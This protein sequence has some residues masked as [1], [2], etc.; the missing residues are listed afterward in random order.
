MAYSADHTVLDGDRLSA[1]IL[2]CGFYRNY[3]LDALVKLLREE[4]QQRARDAIVN[5]ELFRE[6]RWDVA[7]ALA[8]A[9]SQASWSDVLLEARQRPRRDVETLMLACEFCLQQ[10]K[11]SKTMYHFMQYVHSVCN[12]PR[13]SFGSLSSAARS[14]LPAVYSIGDAAKMF[15]SWETDRK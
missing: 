3:S 8:S 13:N 1:Y 5:G 6:D 9:L 2:T 15:A 10:G 4:L 11:D 12:Q 14:Q 7:N